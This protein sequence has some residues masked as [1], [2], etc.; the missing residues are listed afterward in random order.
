[1]K[2]ATTAVIVSV[3]ITAKNADASFAPV[4]F[5]RLHEFLKGYLTDGDLEP[6]NKVLAAQNRRQLTTEDV[7]R[8][9]YV[10]ARSIRENEGHSPYT[11]IISYCKK[12]GHDYDNLHVRVV[13][14][15]LLGME[16][17]VLEKAED[18]KARSC[19]KYQMPADV[20]TAMSI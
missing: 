15:L 14:D 17:M 8:I 6:L 16:F 5:N 11:R 9:A 3:A 10:H 7:T 2:K 13:T 18:R 19:R 12:N 1:M 20:K 4:M